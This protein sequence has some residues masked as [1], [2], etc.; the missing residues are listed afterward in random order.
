[1]QS[2][3]VQNVTRA[4]FYNAENRTLIVSTPKAS[5]YR[6]TCTDLGVFYLH[7]CVDFPVGKTFQNEFLLRQRLIVE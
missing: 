4:A 6:V 1:M 2:I 3:Q 5:N 7:P